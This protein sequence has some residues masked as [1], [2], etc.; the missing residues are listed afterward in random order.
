MN[1]ATNDNFDSKE[2]QHREG[3]QA[4]ATHGDRFLLNLI[5]AR[6]HYLAVELPSGIEGTASNP[7]YHL[8]L[9]LHAHTF[10]TLRAHDQSCTPIELRW[11]WLHPAF[12]AK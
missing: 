5:G 11:Q 8:F 1:I 4:Y 6:R 12:V 10:R 9:S 3:V 2:Y 7:T